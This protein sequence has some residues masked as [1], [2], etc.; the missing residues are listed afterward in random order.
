MKEDLFISN[1]HTEIELIVNKLKEKWNFTVFTI[2]NQSPDGYCVSGAI[3]DKLNYSTFMHARLFRDMIQ[4][5]KG[6]HSAY[7]HCNK[8]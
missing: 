1:D 4:F 8:E 7:I 2:N 5:C 3:S 6:F